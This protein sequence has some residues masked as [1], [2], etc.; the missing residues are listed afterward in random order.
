[1]L[2]LLLLAVAVNTAV[3]QTVPI[4][5]LDC[6]T[7]PVLH[8]MDTQELCQNDFV[9]SNEKLTL[10]V[11][12][13]LNKSIHKGLKCTMH[14]SKFDVVCGLFSHEKLLNIPQISKDDPLPA[15]TCQYLYL[16]KFAHIDGLGTPVVLGNSKQWKYL[17]AGSMSHSKNN[18]ECNGGTVQI[19]GENISSIVEMIT[20]NLETELIDFEISIDEKEVLD[21]TNGDKLSPDVLFPSRNFNVNPHSYYVNYTKP[22]CTTVKI[23]QLEFEIVQYKGVQWYVN[24]DRKIAFKRVGT[25]RVCNQTAISTQYSDIVLFE[26]NNTDQRFE[27]LNGIDLD[28]NQEERITSDFI[29]FHEAQNQA[30]INTQLCLQIV[31]QTQMLPSP[32]HPFAFLKFKGDIAHEIVCKRVIVH[33][34]I[35][36]NRRSYC[37]DSLPIHYKGEKMELKRDTKIIVQKLENNTLSKTPCEYGQLPIFAS[38]KRDIF[39]IA[40]PTISVYNVSLEHGNHAIIEIDLNNITGKDLLFSHAQIKEFKSSLEYRH[41]HENLLR[42]LTHTMCLNENCGQYTPEATDT[43]FPVHLLNPSYMLTNLFRYEIMHYV[44]QFGNICAIV[45]AVYCLMS[46]IMKVFHVCQL[47]SQNVPYQT[48]IKHVIFPA[49]PNQRNTQMGNVNAIQENTNTNAVV[50]YVPRIYR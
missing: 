26:F 22:T 34:I 6:N 33:A 18:V 13:V 30:Y 1:M 44:S 40:N 19:N 45:I 35:G 43:Q 16:Q 21:L 27:N 17:K 41:V 39:L 8:S 47:T 42:I 11:A 5:G 23:D 10:T 3:G 31:S 7:G 28:L 38:T 14:T 49:Y 9:E 4:Y 25:R 12:Q 32:F 20:R 24:R 29:M 50:T 15:S 36:E 48:A 46:W 2:Q 37:S